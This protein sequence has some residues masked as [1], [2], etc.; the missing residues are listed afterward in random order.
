[1]QD[2]NVV[3]AGGFLWF[4]WAGSSARLAARHGDLDVEGLGDDED[5]AE[6]NGCVDVVPEEEE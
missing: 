3:A 1:M 5:V 6:E 4:A 2:G